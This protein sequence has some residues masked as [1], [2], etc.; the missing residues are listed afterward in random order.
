MSA[1]S[2]GMVNSLLKQAFKYGYTN[3]LY[4]LEALSNDA[5]ECLF[6]KI[7]YNEHHCIHDLLPLLRASINYLRPKGHSFE[8][9]RCALELHK[10]YFLP[11]CLFKYV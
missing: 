10:K 8:L 6:R 4:T 11:R 7:Q 9:P 2:V 5:D 3:S 1:D